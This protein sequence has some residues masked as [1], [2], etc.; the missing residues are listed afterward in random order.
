[1]G[2][3][4]V[5]VG[6]PKKVC[7]LVRVE[8]MVKTSAA[9]GVLVLVGGIRVGVSIGLVGALLFTHPAGIRQSTSKTAATARIILLAMDVPLLDKN[10]TIVYFVNSSAN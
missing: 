3:T 7:V 9:V 1:M 8:L 10:I 4:H 2:Q 6:V 5:G